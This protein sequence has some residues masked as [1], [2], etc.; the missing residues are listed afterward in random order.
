MKRQ[1]NRKNGRQRVQVS[2]GPFALPDLPRPGTLSRLGLAL[3]FAI[4]GSITIPRPPDAAAGTVPTGPNPVDTAVR[5]DG[6]LSFV[7]NTG[8]STLS[9][10]NVATDTVVNQ[11]PMPMPPNTATDIDYSAATQRVLVGT[12]TG[13]VYGVDPVTST[14]TLWVATPG[15]NY[16]N[17]CADSFLPGTL[18]WGID[19]TTGTL[20]QLFIGV[21]GVAVAMMPYTT[22]VEL[23][24]KRVNPA[25]PAGSDAFLLALGN[26]PV[27]GNVVVFDRSTW[28]VL[29]PAVIPTP[30]T[31]ATGIDSS[32]LTQDA[33]VSGNVAGGG[34]Q[35]WRLTLNPA[36][37]FTGWTYPF[38]LQTALDVAVAGAFVEVLLQPFPPAPGANIGILD[39]GDVANILYAGNLPV[40]ATMN[41][42]GGISAFVGPS[43]TMDDTYTVYANAGG[44]GSANSESFSNVRG[45][46]V[47]AAPPAVVAGLEPQITSTMSGINGQ[48]AL[49]CEPC[50]DAQN[51][52][53]TSNDGYV[54][55]STAASV[56]YASGEEVLTLPLVSVPG[57]GP[58][59]SFSLTYRSRKDYD[60]RYGNGWF[61][62]QDV[63]LFQQQNGNQKFSNG[64]GRLDTY[65]QSGP[66]YVSPLHYDTTLSQVSGGYA[67]VDRFGHATTFGTSGLRTQQADRH[68][69]TISY[70]YANDRLTQVTDTLSRNYNL[71]Y[72]TTG[73]LSSLTD[74]GGRTWSFS[75][76]YKGD[77][78]KLTTP[79]STQF[80]SGRTKY[81]SYSANSADL[82][83]K[84]NLVSTYNFR[85]EKVQTLSYDSNDL[86]TGEALGAGSY[87]ISYN[88]TN[89][90]RTVVDR[91][92]NTTTWTFDQNAL[93][94]KMERFTKGLRTGEPTSY[95][96]NYTIGSNGFV[97]HVVLP[98]GNRNDFQY[99][100]SYNVTGVRQRTT[101]TSTNSSTDIVTS[102]TYTTYSQLASVTD[103]LGNTTNYTV[104]SS[105]DTTAVQRP[106]V[107]SPSTQNASTSMSYD[108]RGR[109]T[110][111]TDAESRN[112]SLS[113]YTTGAH[114]GYLQS[115]A[116]D[117]SGANAT[118]TLD[119]DQYGNIT[120]VTDA[121]GRT[122]NLTV[123]SEN[124]LVEA[125]A[126]TPFGYRTQFTYDA[127]RNVTGVSVENVD[128]D[129][130]QDPTTPWINT[131][132]SYDALGRTLST[133]RHFTPAVAGTSSFTYTTAG[134]L[135]T[136]TSPEGNQSSFVYDER[137]LLFTSTQGTGTTDAATSTIDYTVNGQVAKVTDPRGNA[138]NLAYDAFDRNTQ[139][140]NEV[141]NY[142][143]ITYDKASQP[144]Q[145]DA[146]DAS[147]SLVASVA[148]Y[149]D[150]VGRLWKSVGYRFGSGLTSSYP[151]IVVT[152]DKSDRVTQVL[153]ELSNASTRGYDSLGRLSTITDA[154][155]NSG[156]YTY[157]ANGNVTQVQSSQVPSGGSAEVFTTQFVYDELNRL[158]Q[159]K[160]I[161]RL[162]SNN[163]LT[164]SYKY[165][166]R[167]D[168]VFATD[169][170]N[171][172]TRWTYDLD[173]RLTKRERALST[174]TS[175]E[176]FVTKIEEAFAYDKNN[177]LTTLTDDN[178]NATGY[179]FDA[180]N[181]A[182]RTDYADGR[183]ISA[184]FD[185]NGNVTGWT[186]QNGTA[187]SNTYD[188][189]N[190]LTARSV[191]RGTGVQGTT[192]EAYTYDAL[193]R[194]LT[195]SDDDYQIENT[196]DSVGN[197]LKQRQG[198]T[199]GSPLWK[200]VQY[201]VDDAGSTSSITYPS[202]FQVGHTRDSI[203]RL[204]ALVDVA[205]STNIAS[206]AWQGV[207]RL[208]TTSNQNGTSTDYT[209]DGFQRVS[210]INHILAGGTGSLHRF[211]Y[212]YDKVHNRRMEKNSYD[213]T[214]IATLPAN[215]QTFLNGRNA[216]GDVYAYDWAYR[217]VDARYDVTNPV[218]E[219]QTPGSQTYVRLVQYTLD[220][221]GNRSQVQT[222]VPPGNPTTVTYSADIVNQY[223]A[224]AGTNRS[225]DNNGNVADDGTYLFHYDYRN[226]MTEAV[227]KST[228]T[229]VATYRYDPLGRRVEKAVNGGVTTRYVLDGVEVVEEYDGSNAWAARY[230]YED[231]IDQPRVMDRAD[232]AD[233]NG[234]SNTSEVLRF[235][236]H[237]SA[238]GNVTEVSQPTGAVV[239]WVTYDVY[240]K[241][242]I[243]DRQGTVVGQ[244][245]VGNP[246]LFTGREYDAEAGLYY[247]RAR[248]YDPNT[249]R[250]MQHDPAAY[251]DGLSLYQ[252]AASSPSTWIDSLGEKEHTKNARPSSRAAHEAGQARALKDRLRSLMRNNP[253][254]KK[255]LRDRGE[256][257]AKSAARRMLAEGGFTFV[258]VLGWMLDAYFTYESVKEYIEEEKAIQDHALGQ[259]LPP[260]GKE[261]T[262]KE[263]EE[264][265]KRQHDFD[266][267]YD[268]YLRTHGPPAPPTPDPPPPTTPDEPDEG[269]TTPDEPDEGHPPP[270]GGPVLPD[271]PDGPE[272]PEAPAPTVERLEL[273]GGA[274]PHDPRHVSGDP[275]PWKGPH[276]GTSGGE[277]GGYCT[278]RPH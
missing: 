206:F 104:S 244:S 255:I 239:E 119:E 49:V 92:S 214:W 156:N 8:N 120:T 109:L 219:V 233:V 74:F 270:S 258:P 130:N 215:V 160:E 203:Y 17:I 128:K 108:T 204:T 145:V 23:Q 84:S 50:K 179:T 278:V 264:I 238:I 45:T 132:V 273:Y 266:E 271:G 220:G 20:Q 249:G 110:S 61:L 57:V 232:I 21:P 188:A 2:Q 6:V 83:F 37:A 142:A 209:Y 148:K 173:S 91:S 243:R 28:V 41:P 237:Q 47:D 152:R 268:E 178:F 94:T 113:Y 226:Q 60:Y 18:G 254:I 208:Q 157:D 93:V 225:H 3:V 186:D 102:M 97:D 194:M 58:E 171:H 138:V 269:P 165:D 250:F 75:Y 38:G 11:I 196:W 211:D 149:Y 210:I 184:T 81:F 199:G 139:V 241:L 240:G 16:V 221:L 190:R 275:D 191:T 25:A 106:T 167:G 12:N 195:A 44:A 260:E 230:I 153:D 158:V 1:N 5:P 51:S 15:A 146:Y 147:N 247:Y 192:A 136:A 187:V 177:R 123:D 162:N 151:T 277:P 22:S 253:E 217:L 263:L 248:T 64:Q 72:D 56:Q 257:A 107:T 71:T 229:S 26:G 33:Y 265:N 176:D 159:R 216:K 135:A 80:P 35:V 251:V 141:G 76:N 125:Q 231:G 30:A 29:M 193:D 133:T 201:A 202:S 124:Y 24:E 205:A 32:A 63:R 227:L 234:N 99:D 181:R 126:A 143:N 267:W 121:N 274:G 131:T 88:G 155:G 170:E 122:T 222:T 10:I 252:Y 39:A 137:G 95:V 112:V 90:T 85:G 189:R 13:L 223:T 185:K 105:G 55:A 103:P 144:T 89:S 70:T 164:T 117:P 272:G 43:M 256:Q 111:F 118:T 4:L 100:S 19:A 242:T 198:Y 168:L 67:T 42:F 46:F 59:A 9:V 36:P 175:I 54:S 87:S 82:R 166:S 69:N 53:P 246:Y 262:P 101:D 48:E 7:L 163:V 224:V 14:V 127:D 140:T 180:L 172:P 134:Q 261:A 116:R 86:I 169:A 98:A 245:A 27:N 129:G 200:T 228:S 62:N 213:A 78:R 207:N 79:T 182:T 161:D 34:G 183:H 31:T 114:A 77:L 218:T 150:E 236:Y 174:G 40:S 259:D 65:Q 96:T 235:T 115:I 154:V 66:N 73:R 197:L 276:G 68:Q 212:L 52:G